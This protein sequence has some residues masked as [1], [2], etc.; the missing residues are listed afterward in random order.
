MGAVLDAGH[1][2][3]FRSVIGSELIGDYNAWSP[4]LTF[5]QLAHQ[6][7]GCL[8]ITAALNQNL[9]DKSVLINSPPQPMPLASDRNG[10][11]IEMPLVA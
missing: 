2:L 8:S 7:F 10:G 11:F 1:D 9:Q 6:A 5:Q 4:T 3:S